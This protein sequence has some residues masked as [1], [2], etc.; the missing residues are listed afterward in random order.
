MAAR[1]DHDVGGLDIAVYDAF[2]MRRVER[3]GH[4]NSYIDRLVDWQGSARDAG[5]EG[6]PFDIFHG[7]EGDAICL[8]DLEHVGYVGMT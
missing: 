1:R 5:I 7:Q 6:L 2:G 4:L 8:A 3:V